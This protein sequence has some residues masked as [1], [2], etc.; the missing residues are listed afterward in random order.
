M[1]NLI[2]KMFLESYECKS[3]NWMLTE[4]DERDLDYQKINYGIS[5]VKIKDDAGLE[6]E[7]KKLT[8]Y[9][10]IKPLLFY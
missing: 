9:R 7:V 5:I 4:Y 2:A 3:E 8:L 1:V 6:D 10:N